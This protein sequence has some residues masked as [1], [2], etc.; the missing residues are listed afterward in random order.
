MIVLQCL[1]KSWY[2]A[3]YRR[4]PAAVNIMNTILE[5]WSLALA[6]G[7]VIARAVKLLVVAIMYIGRIDTPFL[8]K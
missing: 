7:F 2:G 3:F 4:K 1:R 6:T 5:C 8:G